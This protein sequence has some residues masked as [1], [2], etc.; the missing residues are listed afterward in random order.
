VNDP[1]SIETG[2]I[3]DVS[4][5]VLVVDDNGINR[6]KMRMAVEH[7]GHMTGVAIRNVSILAGSSG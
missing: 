7:L 4:A 3:A 5:R 1:S 2:E 6:K